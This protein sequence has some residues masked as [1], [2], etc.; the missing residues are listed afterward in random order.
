MFE[1]LRQLGLGV[2]DA[3]TRLSLNARV[4]IGLAGFLTLVIL[5][6]SVYFGAQP[7]YALLY[8]RLEPAES[9]QIQTWLQE[10]NIPYQLRDGGETVRIPAKDI[11]RA[12]VALGHHLICNSQFIKGFH[13]SISHIGVHH[14]QP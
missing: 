8:N 7:Q 5:G 11:S 2:R 13:H 4:Q 10:Q 12:K 9:G 3:W 14:F 6:G 1:F